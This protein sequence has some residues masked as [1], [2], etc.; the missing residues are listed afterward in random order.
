MTQIRMANKV[1]LAAIAAIH[2]TTFTRQQYS[3]EW[4]NCN[5]NAYPLKRLFIAEISAQIVGYILWGE[6]SGFRQEPVVELEQIAVSPAEQG[7]GIGYALIL[8]SLEDVKSAIAARG[9]TVK[10]VLVTTRA[11]NAAQRLYRKALGARVVATIPALYSAD[12][13]I[14]VATLA[15]KR[16]HIENA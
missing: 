6:K 13:V 2:A 3:E 15:A 1:D 5:L 4:I 14:M 11:D 8:E 7:K 12:E 16:A 10:T 9:A